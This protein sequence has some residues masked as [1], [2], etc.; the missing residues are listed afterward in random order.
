MIEYLATI[1]LVI[2]FVI[3]IYAFMSSFAVFIINIT[4]IGLITAR[5]NRDIKE[6]GI[7]YYLISASI[8][9]FIFIFREY[10]IFPLIFNFM[11]KILVLQI[12]LAL[13]FIFGIAYLV[14]YL[15]N[16]LPVIIGRYRK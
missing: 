6:E 11:E 1:I 2:A 13:I 12:S 16:T 7:L 5:I 4:I 9:A 3:F 8:T 14:K 10:F 15:H